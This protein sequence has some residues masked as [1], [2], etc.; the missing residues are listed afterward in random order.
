MVL[1]LCALK[2]DVSRGYARIPPCSTTFNRV[3]YLGPYPE[4][5]LLPDSD[6]GPWNSSIPTPSSGSRLTSFLGG[7]GQSIGLG[8]WAVERTTWVERGWMQ[9]WDARSLGPF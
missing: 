9:A 5:I 6:L 7:Q 2:P 3:A 4:V 1:L 8:H